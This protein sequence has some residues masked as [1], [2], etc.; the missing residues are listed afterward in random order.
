MLCQNVLD[1]LGKQYEKYIEV[2]KHTDFNNVFTTCKTLY[3]TYKNNNTILG[4]LL[5][6]FKKY[7]QDYTTNKNEIWTENDVVNIMFNEIKPFCDKLVNKFGHVSVFDPCV[8]GGNLLKPFIHEYEDKCVL[9]GCDILKH[10]IML[11]N[12]ELI[13]NNIKGKFINIDYMEQ[14]TK[15]LQTNITIC[16][17]P[18]SKSISKYE[19]IEFLAKSTR[20]SLLCCYIF[21]K[22]QLYK[23]NNILNRVRQ[24]MLNNHYI[25][26]VLNIG[27]IFK[28]VKTNDITI[29]I[30]MSKKL[31]KCNQPCLYYNISQLSSSQYYKKVL[32]QNRYELTKEGKDLICNTK[33]ITFN[34]YDELLTEIND[35]RCSIDKNKL[36]EILIKQHLDKLLVKITDAIYK[37]EDICVYND[38]IKRIHNNVNTMK[39]KQVKLNEL[40]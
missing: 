29:V 39:F 33:P 27:E 3:E 9:Q 40:F 32:K 2:I 22:S 23:Q 26:K 35:N 17:P 1:T 24:E 4:S 20:H 19:A 16:N 28:N 21:P 18:Y 6:Q 10:Y 5:K 37:N 34:N 36:R 12:L 30:T 13:I 11:N 14:D 15:Q 8:G 7:K 25:M 31:F 38:E